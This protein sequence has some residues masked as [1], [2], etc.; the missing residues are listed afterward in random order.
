MKN[1]R[2]R[3]VESPKR[4][5][6]FSLIEIMLVVAIMGMLATM[7]AVGLG[8]RQKK[9]MINLTRADIQT[10]GSCIKLYEVDTGK[11]PDTLESL[12]KNTGEPNWNGPYVD[13]GN[14]QPDKWGTPFTYSKKGDSGF[15]IRSAGPDKQ[16]ST[17]DDLTN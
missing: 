4:N 14:L 12:V 15:E 11:L 16:M 5:A 9:S 10:L 2:T 1:Y 3:D 7:V 17:E 13:G 8:G 6:G